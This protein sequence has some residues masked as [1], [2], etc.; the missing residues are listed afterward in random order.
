MRKNNQSKK[1][2][3][4]E[5]K[6]TQEGIDRPEAP[7]LNK[8]NMQKTLQPDDDTFY[9]IDKI[10]F[11]DKLFKYPKDFNPDTMGLMKLGTYECKDRDKNCMYITSNF[12]I[13]DYNGKTL[14]KY[15]GFYL[16]V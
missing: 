10:S 7:D 11:W 6:E 2:P 9:K 13:L 3:E 8:K 1:S 15:H 16:E 5:K 4:K 12:R 14:R